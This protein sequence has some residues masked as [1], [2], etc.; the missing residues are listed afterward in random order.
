MQAL[1]D[2]IADYE[3]EHGE[4]SEAEIEEATRSTRSR[5]VVVRTAPAEKVAKRSGSAPRPRRG[6]A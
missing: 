4:I 2:F 1:D 5:A 6:G 3:A